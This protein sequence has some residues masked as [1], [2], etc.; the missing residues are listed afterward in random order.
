M[1]D[2][3][4]DAAIKRKVQI[5]LANIKAANVSLFQIRMQWEGLRGNSD[6]KFVLI[7][8]EEAEK[9]LKHIVDVMDD[10]VAALKYKDKGGK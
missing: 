1:S 4:I 2:D 9:S 10:I 7:Y 8:L 3:I 5:T 6:A